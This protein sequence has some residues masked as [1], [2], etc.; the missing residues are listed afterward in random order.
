M[1]VVAG[2]EV[3]RDEAKGGWDSTLFRALS[4]HMTIDHLLDLLNLTVPRRRDS[5]T[6]HP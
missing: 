1:T 4:T 6:F 3:A 5:M 2:V